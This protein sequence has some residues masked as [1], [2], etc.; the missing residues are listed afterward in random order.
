MN[1]NKLHPTVQEF[2]LKM[3]KRHTSAMGASEKE[4][5]SLENIKKV[6]VHKDH[7]KVYY[8]HE[9]YHYHVNGTWY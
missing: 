2:L 3:H 4:K 9:W 7:I 8:K 1:I 5:H 6:T